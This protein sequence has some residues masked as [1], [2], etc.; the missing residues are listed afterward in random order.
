MLELVHSDMS[1]SDEKRPPFP[2]AGCGRPDGP[3]TRRRD[4]RPPTAIEHL[5]YRSESF[6]VAAAGR[7]IRDDVGHACIRWRACI[8]VCYSVASFGTLAASTIARMPAFTTGG[9]SG[10]ASIIA[11]RPASLSTISWSFGDSFGDPVEEA[12][13]MS[14][15]SPELLGGLVSLP[16]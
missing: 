14:F 8:R 12:S 3:A 4:H 6:T 15:V 11:T 1:S 16:S 9:S 5:H 10:Q 7:R 13:R 2:R